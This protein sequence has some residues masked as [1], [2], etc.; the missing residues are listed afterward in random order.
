MS[1]SSPTSVP[2]V[3]GND[4]AVFCIAEAGVNHNGKVDLAHKLID[5]ALK[6]GAD[7]IKFQTF[8][9]E[10]LVSPQALKAAYQK[11]ATGE[12]SQFSM[13]KALELP[14]EAWRELKQHCDE[15]GIFFLST[16]FDERS[17]DLLVELEVPLLKLGSGELTHKSLIEY[18]AATGL[19][20]LLSTGMADRYEVGAALSW[21]RLAFQHENFVSA[22]RSKKPPEI[23][24][25][26]GGKIGLLHCISSYPA[27]LESLNLKAIKTLQELFAVP[28]GFSDHS[29]GLDAIPIA[30]AAGACIVEKHFTLDQTLSGPDHSMSLR[31]EELE[32]LIQEVRKTEAMLGH[33]RKEAHSLEEEVRKVARKSIVA[34]KDIDEGELLTPDNIG[35]R[36]PGTGL[37]PAKITQVFNQRTQKAVKAGELIELSSLKRQNTKST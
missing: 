32:E 27:P 35:I 2:R 34:L 8:K 7:A 5:A 6:S 30:V 4:Q 3:I 29:L 22:S 17:C 9:A 31:P 24:Y 10:A 25:A 23:C 11:E 28:I 26:D 36:R 20:L 13:L 19:P 1:P 12:G 33:G 18:C 15:V 16:P 14:I 21:V 37:V